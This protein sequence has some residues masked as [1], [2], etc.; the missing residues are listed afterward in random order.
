MLLSVCVHDTAKGHTNK[1]EFSLL[2]HGC[3]SI[4]LHFQTNTTHIILNI[5][6]YRIYLQWK[7]C[8]TYCQKFPWV[9]CINEWWN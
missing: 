7:D 9:S 5:F 4:I 1:V 8:P 3:L 6:A 2:I